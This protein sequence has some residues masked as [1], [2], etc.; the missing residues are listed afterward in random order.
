MTARVRDNLFIP[1]FSLWPE[2][3]QVNG[4]LGSGKDF[5]GLY[6]FAIRESRDNDNVRPHYNGAK[7][8]DTETSY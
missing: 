5:Q 8:P 3:I 1:K 6:P 7:A 2:T 4:E